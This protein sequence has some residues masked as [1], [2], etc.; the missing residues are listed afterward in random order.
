MTRRSATRFISLALLIALLPATAAR[1]WIDT[2]HK[3]IAM[4]TWDDLT[5]AARAK[6]TEILKRHPQ[7]ERVLMAGQPAN[8]APE[9][10]ARHAFA[11]AA[12]WPDLLRSPANP[13]HTLYHHPNWHYIDIP[14]VVDHQPLPATPA[15][16][17]AKQPGPQNVV[18]ALTQSV[19]E[20]K[21]PAIVGAD[22]AIA[23]CW[24]LH[25]VGDIHQPMHAVTM[26]SPE[27]PDG[28]QG[29]NA[30]IVLRDPPYIDSKVRLHL[31]WD[32]LPGEFQSENIDGYL[33][34]GLRNDPRFSRAALKDALA[35]KDFA[36]W[37]QESHELAVKDAYLNGT[38]PFAKTHE[39]K[40]E[41][42]TPIPGVPAGYMQNAEQVALRQMA[43]AA[44]RTADLL[45]AIYDAK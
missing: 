28:D 6:V 13:M 18:E 16:Q 12:T 25:L 36:A 3:I 40:G 45:N 2:G 7:Y 15:T 17:P 14:F 8:L 37:A 22:Q 20:L 30:I 26:V 27:F 31:L 39:P 5:P 24:T 29:G 43:L 33:A 44:Y 10:A 32:E 4:M 41:A 42:R 35:V 9:E 34:A 23:L 38:L 19:A 21:D 1:A 11:V